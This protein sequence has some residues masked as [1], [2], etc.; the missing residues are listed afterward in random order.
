VPP[1]SL[2]LLQESY[3]IPFG[4]LVTVIGLWTFFVDAKHMKNKQLS[5][6]AKVCRWL[7]LLYAVLGLPTAILLGLM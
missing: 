2:T 5:R 1:I 6:E 3:S 4:A 7:G